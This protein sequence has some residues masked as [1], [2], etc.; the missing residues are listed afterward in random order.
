MYPN[1]LFH[2]F[3]LKPFI[4]CNYSVSVFYTSTDDTIFRI[5]GNSRSCFHISVF[6]LFL[7]Q[8]YASFFR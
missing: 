3:I 1:L 6:T 5:G 8:V 7:L 2:P 4:V